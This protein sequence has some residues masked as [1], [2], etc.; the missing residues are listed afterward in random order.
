MF[1][2][3]QLSL[4][5]KCLRQKVLMSKALIFK[6]N[7]NIRQKNYMHLWDKDVFVLKIMENNGDKHHVFSFEFT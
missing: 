6:R 2:I 1:S 3:I 4:K 7:Q 5:N